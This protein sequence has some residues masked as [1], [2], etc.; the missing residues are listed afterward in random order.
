MRQAI[1]RVIL[2]LIKDSGLVAIRLVA[3]APV[4]V[5]VK[6]RALFFLL[7]VVVTLVVDPA[8]VISKD[9]PD[10]SLAV[11]PGR[12]PASRRGGPLVGSGPR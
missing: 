3:E 12:I 2:K 1:V 7:L 8:S 5:E 6:Q 4:L 11:V 9:V 10:V